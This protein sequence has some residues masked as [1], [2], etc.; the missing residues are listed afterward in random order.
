LRTDNGWLEYRLQIVQ[1][2]LLNQGTQ[3]ASDGSAVKGVTPVLLERDEELRKAREDLVAM[4]TVAVEWE[5]E[6][7]STRSELQLDRT[8]LEGAQS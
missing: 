5:M 3:A 4:Q 2:E 7:A 8:I 6:L 1:D